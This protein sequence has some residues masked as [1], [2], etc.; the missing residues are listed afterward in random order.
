M[1]HCFSRRKPCDGLLVGHPR[2][3]IVDP[4]LRHLGPLRVI[5]HCGGVSNPSESSA[6]ASA[7]PPEPAAALPWRSHAREPSV[8]LARLAASVRAR[9][10]AHPRAQGSLR[11]TAS[12]Q[13]APRCLPVRA[14]PPDHDRQGARAA[15]QNPALAAPGFYFRAFN[16]KRNF[17]PPADLS[18][19]FEIKSVALHNGDNVGVV[20]PWTWPGIKTDIPPEIVGRIL[21]DIDKGMENGQPVLQ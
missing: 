16:G 2:G 10:A 12:P 11:R 17:A 15:E 21:A 5:R 4:P 7:L 3:R 19:W 8:S 14:H 20:T 9:S 13:P 18:D 1:Q 6:G